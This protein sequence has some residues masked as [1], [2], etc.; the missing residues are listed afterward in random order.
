M[1]LPIATLST[2]SLLFL[3][4]VYTSMTNPVV[5]FDIDF[6]M[7]LDGVKDINGN[8]HLDDGTGTGSGSG[9]GTILGLPKLSAAEQ[10]VGALFGPT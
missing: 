7:A 10:L 4:V 2:I 8:Y 6:Y 3:G 9:A 5:D 1:I